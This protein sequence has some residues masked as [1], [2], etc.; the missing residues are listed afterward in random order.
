LNR[1]TGVTVLMVSH[2][3]ETVRKVA[4]RVLCLRDGVVHSQGTPA[5]VLTPET[6]SATFGTRR[7]T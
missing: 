2:D 4:G 5:E 7:T 3:L 1:E 6:V